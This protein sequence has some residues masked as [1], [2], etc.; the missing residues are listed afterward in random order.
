[1]VLGLIVL[2]AAVIVFI[3]IRKRCPKD[4]QQ[5]S[6]DKARSRLNTLREE[7]DTAPPHTIATRTSIIIRSYLEEAF[8]DP[9]LFETDE[10]FV[11]RPTALQSLPSAARN[12]VSDFL[13]DLSSL[14]Y[15]PHKS[16][17]PSPEDSGVIIDHAEKLLS[18]IELHPSSANETEH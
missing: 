12:E 16:A 4:L 1:M 10:E 7:T 2:L 11:L 18:V 5:T 13:H 9:A 15:A 14:K 3:I 8:Q 17:R 6:L